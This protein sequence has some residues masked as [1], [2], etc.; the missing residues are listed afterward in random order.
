[1]NLRLLPLKA[2]VLKH[3]PLGEINL[4]SVATDAKSRA[5]SSLLELCRDAKEENFK[6]TDA[7]SRAESI[8]LELCLDAKVGSFKLTDANA[9]RRCQAKNKNR[10][11]GKIVTFYLGFVRMT[12][13]ITFLPPGS[14]YECVSVC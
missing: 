8:L 9:P 3:A 2:I 14:F 5:E 1:M 12:C 6:L 11:L 13:S 10:L 4:P 7:K